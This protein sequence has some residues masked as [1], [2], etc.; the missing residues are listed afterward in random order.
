MTFFIL[1]LLALSF[2]GYWS[3]RKALQP[4]TQSVIA[5]GYVWLLVFVVFGAYA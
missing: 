5:T 1:F 4:F 2:A 3:Q